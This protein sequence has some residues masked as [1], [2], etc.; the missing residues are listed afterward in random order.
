[1][2]RC[3]F[4]FRCAPPRALS[5]RSPKPARQTDLPS[6]IQVGPTFLSDLFFGACSIF[7]CCEKR[8]FDL[9]SRPSNCVEVGP[10]L[11]PSSHILLQS[12]HMQN[13]QRKFTHEVV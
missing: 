5:T 3:T 4:R 11:W 7:G 2:R 9:Y 13:I 6:A 1:M 8:E 10:R 12:D